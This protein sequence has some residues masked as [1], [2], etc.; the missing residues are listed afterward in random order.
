[1]FP[2]NSRIIRLDQS[3]VIKQFDCDD[4]DLNEFLLQDAKI[5]L[6]ELLTVT[7]ILENDT[8]TLGFWS[9]LNDKIIKKDLEDGHWLAFWDRMPEGKKY[10]SYPSMKIARLGISNKYKKQGIGTAVLDHLKAKFITNN[11]TGCKFITVDAYRKSLDFYIKNSF[12]FFKTN[13]DDGKSHT[14]PMYF[15]L[16]PLTKSIQGQLPQNIP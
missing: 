8:D 3:T 15:D 7:Y 4:N 1:M 9:L 10:T 5:S 13:N 11:R 12:V 6:E 14:R 2:A 16:L